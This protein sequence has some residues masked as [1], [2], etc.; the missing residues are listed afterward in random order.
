MADRTALLFPPD[1]CV[2]EVD[3]GRLSMAQVTV[4]VADPAAPSVSVTGTWPDLPISRRLPLVAGVLVVVG[5]AIGW[6]LFVQLGP[7]VFRPSAGYE[8]FAGL[9][10]ITPAVERLVYLLTSG[11][12]VSTDADDGAHLAR[13]QAVR[14]LLD[15]DS[16]LATFFADRSAWFEAEADRLR[17]ER[18]IIALGASTA[19]AYLACG[20]LGI[21]LV[22]SIVD[23]S[24]GVRQI[25]SS[26]GSTK[27]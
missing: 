1:T 22:S 13:A 8:V 20:S 27:W 25:E 2:N 11:W 26:L 14:A 15:G 7:G 23:T 21:L 12:A 24:A 19:I 10:V 6:V 4:G 17:R 18:S 3:E 9:I 5:L 16:E